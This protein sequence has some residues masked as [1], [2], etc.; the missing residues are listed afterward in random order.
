M[1]APQF[2]LQL[3]IWGMLAYSTASIGL[4][5][6]APL[7]DRIKKVM[8]RSYTVG[9]FFRLRYGKTAWLIFLVLSL[10]YSIT[11]LVSMAMAGGVVLES[12]ADIKYQ[13]GMSVILLVCTLYTLRGGLYAVIGTDFVQSIIILIGI[14]IIGFII[15][16][17]V[18]VAEIHQNLSKESPALLDVLFPAAIMAVFNNLL[19]GIGEIFQNNIWWSRA[20]AMREGVGKKSFLLAGLIWFPVPIAAGFIALA[21]GVLDVPIMSPDMVGPLVAGKV[22][23]QTGAII[24]FIVVFA[25]LASS[26]DSLLAATSDLVAEDV[27]KR[28]FGG[29]ANLKTVA[30]ICILSIALL[31]WLVCLP[32]IATLAK[33]LFFAGPMV[34]SMI[35]PVFTGLFSKRVSSLA[36]ILAMVLGTIAGLVVYFTIGWYVATLVSAAVSMVVTVAVSALQKEEFDFGKLERG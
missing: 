19:F 3:G 4:F 20:F 15:V 32:R 26:I 11:W 22:L 21:S 33:V 9:D 29:T 12:L 6:F 25:S 1:L 34:G 10:F 2:A 36:A 28:L 18:G 35:W 24:I 14:V 8:P 17:Q 7:A 13:V 27:Y 23:G 31:T 16:T 30:Q 5:L